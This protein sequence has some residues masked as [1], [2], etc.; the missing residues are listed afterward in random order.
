MCT[1]YVIDKLTDLYNVGLLSELMAIIIMQTWVWLGKK[2]N[3]RL[4]YEV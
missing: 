2:R 1:I 3:H 4:G